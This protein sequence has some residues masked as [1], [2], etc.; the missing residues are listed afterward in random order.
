MAVPKPMQTEFG[1]HHR[2]E[3]CEWGLKSMP[4]LYLTGSLCVCSCL[5]LSDEF[6]NLFVQLNSTEYLQLKGFW[7]V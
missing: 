1:I 7:P 6:E 2:L 3:S 5:A 4:K